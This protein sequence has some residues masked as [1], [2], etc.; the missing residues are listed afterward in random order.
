MRLGAS[1]IKIAAGGGYASPTDPIMSTQY[2]FEEMK[3]AADAATDF[4]T[5][6][7]MHA[8]TPRAVNR[9]IDAGIKDVGHG[10]LL[11]RATL[12]RMAD[13]GISLSTQPFTVCNEPHL[14]VVSNAK[15]AIVC[16]G[17]A[18]MYELIKEIPNLKVTFGT[19]LFNVESAADQ[20]Q[21]L[22]RLST[23]FEPVEILRMATGNARD[24]LAMSGDKNPYTAG[25]IGVIEAGAYADLLIVEGNPLDDISILGELD[26]LLVI[27]KD[28]VIFKNTLE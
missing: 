25:P 19:D 22:D 16:A 24:L 28:G 7:T 12:Q 5:Y 8:Y 18:N 11:D 23:W 27:M 1:Q 21:Q 6:V 26:N 14:S 15:L 4:G 3:A 13:E 10:Q 17:T 2:T 20:V 9:A